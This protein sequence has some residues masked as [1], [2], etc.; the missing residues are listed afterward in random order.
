MERCG[1]RMS[2]HTESASFLQTLTGRLPTKKVEPLAPG[3]ESTPPTSLFASLTL[4]CL[5]M[6]AS[7]LVDVVF[8]GC[9]VLLNAECHWSASCS[10]CVEEFFFSCDMN[11][12]CSL[13]NL[14][15]EVSFYCALYTQVSSAFVLC[16]HLWKWIF[17]SVHY[18][19]KCDIL[20]YKHRVS[21]VAIRI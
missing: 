12:G 3:E 10:E 11:V 2:S 18:D 9:G 17:Q 7:G 1:N 6:C 14:V 19:P 16:F 20:A 5:W 15:W 21:W 8:G 13:A 4:S